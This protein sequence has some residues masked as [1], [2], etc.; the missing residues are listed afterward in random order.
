MLTV[1][2]AHPITG[3]S[4]DEVMAYFDDL[5]SWLR[6]YGYAVLNPMGGKTHLR[7][8]KN[9]DAHG[10][11]NP[12]STNHAIIERDRWMVVQ[13][14][15]IVLID[16]TGASSVSIGCMME[17]AW[18]HDRGKHTLVVMETDNIHRHAFVLEAADVLF[19]TAQDARYYLAE[20]AL[21]ADPTSP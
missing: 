8:E 9:L 12:V 10:Y 2:M 11:Q 14:A 21:Q 17:L 18:A 3:L 13:Q 19:N 4:Y 5:E 6:S 15:D 1:Y 7:T 20:L 16:L